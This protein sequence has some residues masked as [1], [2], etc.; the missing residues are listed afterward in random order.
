MME[1][2]IT[3]A[4]RTISTPSTIGQRRRRGRGGETGG[5]SVDGEVVMDKAQPERGAQ[6]RGVQPAT[7]GGPPSGA[8]L[9]AA[10]V[11]GHRGDAATARRLTADSD[12]AVRAAA[13]G[14]LGR[15]GALRPDT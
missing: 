12:P 4:A 9:R 13:Y 15:M 7:A 8:P 6:P 5:N 10:V 1:E 14:A 2:A 3:S 11:A